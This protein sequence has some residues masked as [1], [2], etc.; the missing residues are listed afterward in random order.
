M[1]TMGVAQHLVL[2][3]TE[4]D[5]LLG[6]MSVERAIYYREMVAR[7]GHH[8][9]VTW[10]M[11]EENTNTHAERKAF[12]QAFKDLDPYD[13]P[14]V[15]HTFP[16]Q[17]SSL[18]DPLVGYEPMDGMSLQADDPRAAL[19]K[20]GRKLPMQVISGSGTGMRSDHCY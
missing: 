20:S 2:Q 10:N 12:M 1:D 14:V 19:S 16:G 18:Y 17:V 9:G 4:N 13:H 15:I 8:N 11:G 7:F 3:E 6:G 5:Q